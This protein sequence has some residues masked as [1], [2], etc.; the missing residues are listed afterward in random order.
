MKSMIAL[1][2]VSLMSLSAFAEKKISFNYV[3]KD[4]GELIEVYSKASGQK[5]IIDSTVRGKVSILNNEEVTL[6][7]AFNQLTSALAINGFTYVKTGDVM[8]V[9]NARAAQR[10]GIEVFTN[11][12]PNAQPTRMVMWIVD[13]KHINAASVQGNIGRLINS[14]YGEMQ[15][16]H[17][18]N[19]IIVSDWSS[20]IP[21]IAEMIK[22]LDVK[23]T[24]QMLKF[25]AE[26][27]AWVKE[28]SKKKEQSEKII[29]PESKKVTE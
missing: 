23:S 4:L 7:D 13:L 21:R 12:L 17:D 14:S 15:S 16:V 26:N 6:T 28:F 18:K 24:P 1:A 20:S 25:A 19:Q 22:N 27:K 8:T 3:S 2:L 10:D 5:F 9:R 29:A 11:T